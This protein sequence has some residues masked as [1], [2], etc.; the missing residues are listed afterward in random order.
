[1]LYRDKKYESARR[2]LIYSLN[3]VGN[4]AS[5]VPNDHAVENI[6]IGF[7]T[8]QGYIILIVNGSKHR[9]HTKARG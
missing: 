3:F 8:F 1:M 4:G 7:T 9:E 5:A 6:F 2:K